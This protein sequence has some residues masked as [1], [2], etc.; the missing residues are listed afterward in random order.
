MFR[1]QKCVFKGWRN[2]S[3]VKSS[4]CHNYEGQCSY[5]TS[6]LTSLSFCNQQIPAPRDPAPFCACTNMPAHIAAHTFTHNKSILKV[7]RLS[8]CPL[9]EY[10]PLNSQNLC[11][12]S[13]HSSAENA[14]SLIFTW[15]CTRFSDSLSPCLC[16]GAPK[17]GP[18]QGKVWGESLGNK[19]PNKAQLHHFNPNHLSGSDWQ[20]PTWGHGSWSKWAFGYTTRHWRKCNLTWSAAGTVHFLA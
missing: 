9:Y 6:H 17:H 12:H 18:F 4:C 19:D 7:N 5:P 8:P 1:V 10:R 15:L 2:D 20:P 13:G 14:F 11:L 16:Q 3:A